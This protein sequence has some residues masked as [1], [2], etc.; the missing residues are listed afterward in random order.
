MIKQAIAYTD[1]ARRL[2]GKRIGELLTEHKLITTAELEK[3]LEIQRKEGGRLG[4]VLIKQG[5]LKYEDLLEMLSS[6]LK[7]P[8]VDMRGRVIQPEILN[9]IPE[10]IARERNIIP[11]EMVEDKLV[12]VMG[13]PEDII[14][15][16][17]INLITG[18]K[19]HI[20]LGSP[21][22]IEQAINR[23]YGSDNELLLADSE[24]GSADESEL[25]PDT[26]IIDSSP[27]IQ[28]LNKIIDQAVQDRASDIH[29]EPYKRKLRVRFRIDGILQ[30]KYTLPISAH[31]ALLTRLKILSKMNIAEH[32]RPQDGQ[33]SLKAGQRNVDIRVA[34][35]GTSQSERATMRILDK[36]LSLFGLEQL[37]FVPETLEQ[38]QDMLRSAFGMILVG[39]PTG[40][41]KTT[42]LYA[43][44]NHLNRDELNIMTIEDPIEYNFSDITQIQVN[45]KSGLTF[46][47]AL[48]ATL[49]HD[50]D[51]ILIGE[52]RDPDTA[53]IAVQSA[54]TGHLVLASI[55]ANDVASMLFRLID[56][57]V[58]PYL[59]STTLIGL[60]AQRM[61]RRICS[62]CSGTTKISTEEK[63]AYYREMGEQL[64]KAHHGEGCSLCATTGYYGRTGIFELLSM[65]DKIRGK[66]LNGAVASEIRQDAVSQGMITMGHAGMMKVKQGI[67]TIREVL[68]SSYAVGQ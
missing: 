28:N 41:G 68:R 17:D 56:L 14:T 6:Q 35:I 36:S 59:I 54:L 64:A 67:T 53:K 26:E 31:S 16:D 42:T 23:N 19:I 45:E 44:I 27:V 58:E 1:M 32:R 3:A 33:F 21:L 15:I 5:R 62:R 37:G 29:I 10:K 24:S 30:D 50:P 60:L 12:I 47:T 20:A 61:V 8:I 48:K 34:T 13:Y 52:I 4:E 2:S 57:G 7:V 38:M 18:K 43:M 49:R 22:D 25:G 11:V 39:G 63:N 55:H 65:N 51:V 66:L 40:S 46:S 9:L